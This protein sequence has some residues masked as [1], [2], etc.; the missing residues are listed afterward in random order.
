M[1]V[2]YFVFDKGHT[3]NEACLKG[4]D[5]ELELN[6]NCDSYELR[7]CSDLITIVSF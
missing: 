7:S 1:F 3:F 4:L 5:V 2:F 6:Y